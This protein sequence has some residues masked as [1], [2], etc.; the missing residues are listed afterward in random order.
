MSKATI[1]AATQQDA[2]FLVPLINQ[3]TEGLGDYL[4]AQLSEV[5]QDP[6]QFALQRVQ[7]ED[8]GISYTKAWVAETANRPAGCL[9]AYRKPDR[10]EPVDPS[11][12][13]L[14]R[15]I[16]E[17]EAEAY[18]TGYVF[19]LSTLISAQGRGI[20]TALLN[21]AERFRGPNGM[22]MIVADNNTSAKSLY[23]HLGY[24]AVSEKKMVKNGWQSAGQNWIL[25]IKP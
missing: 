8:A 17:L 20:G 19:V 14:V 4:W 24:K 11:V 12:P 1:R 18:G 9:I 16:L 21:F 3:A 6:R 22:S 15:P 7:S 2:A 25:M 23:E 10:P 13:A 5:R